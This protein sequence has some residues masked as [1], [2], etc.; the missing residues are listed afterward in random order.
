VVL[1]GLAEPAGSLSGTRLVAIDEVP[2][3]EID[4][5]DAP[6]RI[7]EP[8]EPQA[9]SL[10][11]D[12][13]RDG[14]PGP[15]LVAPGRTGRSAAE[16][17]RPQAGDSLIWR[18]VDP[19]LVELTDHEVAELRMRWSITEWNEAM[20]A[21]RVA[22]EEALDWTH[23]DADGNKWGVSPGKLH[24]GGL[25]LPLPVNFG[26]PPGRSDEIDRRVQEYQAAERQ[27]GR[28][29][30]WETWEQ[31]AKEIRARKDREREQA[32]AQRPDTTRHR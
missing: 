1:P 28:A 21:E 12:P 24:L 2:E 18:G 22:A 20:A 15:G 17:L 14:E 23:T 29:R 10:E 27:A 26:P 8:D 3:S 6:E 30:V 16:I 31:R 25:T 9:P 5:P 19:A 13:L 11:G 7:E 32:R 4:D